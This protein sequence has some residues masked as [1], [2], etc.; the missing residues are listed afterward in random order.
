M[1]MHENDCKFSSAAR[2]RSA[3]ATKQAILD[4]AKTCFMRGGYDQVGVREIAGIAG[5]DPALVNRYFG[6]K[7]G[8]FAE[9]VS[10]KI[11]IRPLLAGDLDTLGE[12]LVRSI[13]E[14]QR[15][16]VDHDPLLTLLRSHTS[17]VARQKLRE[18]ML[19]GVV[20]PLT[21]RL[22]GPQRE[23]RAEMIGSILL[24]ML[25]FRALAGISS[26]C[27]AECEIAVAAP[28][29]QALIDGTFQSPCT[30]ETCE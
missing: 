4:A 12:R 17:D 1:T 24:G 14:K 16:D 7:E 23:Q 5:I 6:S 25:T 11:D 3:L 30:T 22:E 9:V 15:S 19:A 13:A 29:V 10:R 2:K 27:G 18:A 8:L 28:I 20:E 21:T 26:N